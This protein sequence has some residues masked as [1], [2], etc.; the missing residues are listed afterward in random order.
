MKMMSVAYAPWSVVILFL[1][2]LA[3]AVQAQESNGRVEPL[4]MILKTRFVPPAGY[5]REDAA[6]DSFA[7]Y[8][9]Q[10]P[11]KP[12]GAVVRLFDGRDKPGHGVY[13][14]VVD[15]PIGTRDLHQCADA[16][17]RLRA[18]YLFSRRRY[19]D[20]RFRFTSGFLAEYS[21]WRRGE[22]IAV[23]GNDAR[24]VAGGAPGNGRRSFWRYLET[25]FAFAGTASLARELAAVP[26]DDLRVGDVF[27]QPGHPGHAVLVVDVAVESRNGRRIFLLAQ[28]YIPAQEIQVLQNPGDAALS[29]W[30]AADFATE[31]VTPE[32]TF[33]AG[34]RMRFP[35]G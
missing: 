29:P 7:A 8:L 26:G 27:I 20:I 34:D 25:V 22:R 3:L 2:F 13:A 9:R 18:D 23:R 35:E 12:H 14:A 31:L 32:W 1:L 10:L 33:H 21:R 4:G 15:L 5:E 19:D 28:S 16:V 6:G 11:L 24:W 30:Y 17:I